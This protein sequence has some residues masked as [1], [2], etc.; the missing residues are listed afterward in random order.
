[1]GRAF[2]HLGVISTGRFGETM[3]RFLP[4]SDPTQPLAAYTIQSEKPTR[5]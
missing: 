5:S 3:T 2:L 1:M 4:K